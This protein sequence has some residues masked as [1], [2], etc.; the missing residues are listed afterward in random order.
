MITIPA[1]IPVPGLLRAV[2]SS[3]PLLSASLPDP[4]YSTI[5]LSE[6]SSSVS[7]SG[8]AFSSVLFSSVCCSFSSFVSAAPVSFALSFASAASLLLDAPLFLEDVPPE[9]LFPLDAL[10][11]ELSFEELP[12]ELSLEELLPDEFPDPD[13]L[14]PGRIF[15]G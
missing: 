9:E 8:S 2:C 12:P 4:S 7:S 3:C 1:M 13:E 14:P 6:D 5:P 15:I 10:L 11:P